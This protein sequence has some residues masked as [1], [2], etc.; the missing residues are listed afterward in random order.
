MYPDLVGGPYYEAL[1]RS[2]REQVKVRNEH[3]STITRRWYENHIYPT[4]G[5]VT[6]FAS[7]VTIRKRAEQAI[8]AA[9]K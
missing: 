9:Y 4:D 3:Y 8:F 1:H 6:V 7:N 5:G 2:V